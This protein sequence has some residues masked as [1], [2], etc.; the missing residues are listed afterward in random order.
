[1]KQNKII[2]ITA[3]ACI[4]ATSLLTYCNKKSSS[5]ILV[6]CT[7]RPN[8]SDVVGNNGLAPLL[9]TQY[10]ADIDLILENGC[11]VTVFVTDV[12]WTTHDNKVVA[13]ELMSRTMSTDQTAHF[14]GQISACGSVRWADEQ[15]RDHASII[16]GLQRIS[17]RTSRDCRNIAAF[18]SGYHGRVCA[19]HFHPLADAW[20][21]R[22]ELSWP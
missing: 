1:M 9:T 14:L 20:V 5:R 15:F 19:V 3:L 11:K 2:A 8:L 16:L 13:M 22:L 7:I 12:V 10:N 17:A 4:F 18:G 6:D 21:V